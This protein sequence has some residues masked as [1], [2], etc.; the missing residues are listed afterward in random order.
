MPRRSGDVFVTYRGIDGACAAAVGLLARP[1]AAVRIASARGVAEALE[2]IRADRLRPERVAV[3]GIGIACPWDDLARAAEALGR[4]GARVDW[5]CGRGYLDADRERLEAFATP[6]FHDAGTNAAAVAAHLGVDETPD[7]RRILKLAACDPN[8]RAGAEAPRR[9]QADWA[10]LIRAAVAQYL[11]YNDTE[12]YPAVIRRL[13]AGT[14]DDADRHLVAVFREVGDRYILL[15]R[16]PAIRECKRRIQRAAEADRA[17][18][19]T[20]E[21]GTG[22]EHVAHLLRERSGLRAMGPFV[23]VNCALF[24]GNAGLVNSALFGHVRGAFTGATQDRAGAFAAANGGIL[25]LDEVGELPPEV[26]PKLLRVLEDGWITPEGCDEPTRRVDVRVL[27]AT[28]RDLPALVRAGTFRADLYHRLSTLRLTVPPLREHPE[29]IGPIVERRLASLAAEGRARAFDA[30]D[31][32]ALAAC[33]WPGNV[34]QLLKLVDRAVLLDLP[35]AE[36]IRE[37][38]ALATEGITG[39]DPLAPDTEDE[40]L[41]LAEIHRRA[42]EGALAACGG[43]KAAAARALGISTNTLRGY[44]PETE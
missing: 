1:D 3:C 14:M 38:R 42:A 27:A 32:A 12:T 7:A 2:Q 31:L 41:A 36:V 18:L 9:E 29:D 35:V 21:S 17:V 13:A 15:G 43:N 30:A 28:N 39:A 26:Q 34:R 24:A 6:V 11:K 37:E 8:L 16:S 33:P 4:D 25:F 10:D 44:L 23:P 40:I 20:G 5:L 22:K 19:I